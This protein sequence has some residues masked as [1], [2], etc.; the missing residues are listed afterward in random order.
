VSGIIA[1]TIVVILGIAVWTV[2]GVIHIVNEDD[3]S[4]SG[5]D[6]H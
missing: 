2:M 6:H 5:G 3:G 4:E 1:L